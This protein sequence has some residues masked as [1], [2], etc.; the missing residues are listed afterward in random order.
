[1]SK[2]ITGVLTAIVTP[3]DGQGEFNPTALRAQIQ[4]QMQY[5]NG[6]FCTVPTVN[7]SYYTPMKKSRSPKPAWMK[8]Q[9][10]CR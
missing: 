6:I 3:F 5:G 7:S 9:A 8:W 10:R 4:R 2:R 1:M